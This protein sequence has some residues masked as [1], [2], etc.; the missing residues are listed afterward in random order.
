MSWVHGN[1]VDN[2]R[3]VYYYHHPLS[4]LLQRLQICSMPL[5]EFSPPLQLACR[6]EPPPP[7]AC[8]CCVTAFLYCLP[9]TH[10]V[11]SFIIAIDIAHHY[12]VFR[13][14]SL[15]QSIR[16][17]GFHFRR[18]FISLHFLLQGGRLPCH[19]FVEYATTTCPP[20]APTACQVV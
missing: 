14:T 5:H 12:F 8:L 6:H 1:V 4:S 20:A 13:S 16:R 18:R 17:S 7:A 19:H 3:G 10:R 2:S 15:N 9:V 11:H